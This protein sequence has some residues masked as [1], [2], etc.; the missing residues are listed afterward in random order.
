MNPP[1]SNAVQGGYLVAALFTGA[2]LGGLSLVFKEITE[3]LGCLLGGFC[4][5]MW[6][7]TVKSGGLVTESGAQTGFIIAFTVGFWCLSFSHYTRSYGLILCTSISGAT[8][9]T[10]GIDCYSR[11][12]LKEF[13]VYIW[14][15]SKRQAR[16]YGMYV[17]LLT[18]ASGLNN[19]LF[20]LN[21]N[22][23]PVSRNIRVELAITVIVTVFGVIAQMRL[24]KVIK[25]RRVKEEASRKEAEKKNEETDAEVGRQLE[26]KNLQE[27]AEWENMYGNGAANVP[28]MTE[29]AVAEDSRRGSDGFES[30]NQDIEKGNSFEMKDMP[31]PE[32]SADASDSGRNLDAVEEVE[33]EAFEEHQ[34]GHVIEPE[35]QPSQ[36]EIKDDAPQTARPVTM[37]PEPIVREDTGSEHGAVVGSEPGTPRSK[38]VSGMSLMKRL[39]RRSSN[40][41]NG[42]LSPRLNEK[43]ESEEALVVQDDATSSVLGVADDVPSICSSV[44]SEC[45]AAEDGKTPEECVKDNLPAKNILAEVTQAELNSQVPRVTQAQGQG[46]LASS[47]LPHT[48]NDENDHERRHSRND[49]QIHQD[50]EAEEPAHATVADIQEDSHL[51]KTEGFVLQVQPSTQQEGLS[52]QA[53]EDTPGEEYVKQADEGNQAP[54]AE[55]AEEEA[56]ENPPKPDTELVERDLDSVSQEKPLKRSVSARLDA[57]TVKEI[58]EQTSM[59]VNSF[60]TNEWA[61]HLADAEI[62][63]V[64]PIQLDNDVLE[65]FPADGEAAAP[66]DVEGL[67]QTPLNSLPPPIVNSPTQ[68]PASP[69]QIRQR[70]TASA[71]AAP[72][73]GVP[74]S[75]TRNNIYDMSGARSPPPMGR[76]MSSASL[77]PLQTR[78][79]TLSPIRSKSTPFLTIT[80]PDQEQKAFDSPRWSGPPPLLAVRENMVRNRM[81]SNSL[82][83]DP[84]ASRSQSR[85]SQAD[86]TLV[87]SSPMSIPE[88]RNEAVGKGAEDAD[89]VPLSKRRAML[90]RQHMRSPSTTS[91]L[92]IDPVRSSTL[93]PPDSGRSAAAMAAWRQSVRE[94][95]SQRDPLANPS[96]P[97][98]P[99]KSERPRAAWGSVQ[100]MRDTSV[101]HVEKSIAD[102]MQRGGM[103]D[104]HRQAMRRMQASANR[105]L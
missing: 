28:S 80:T 93:N 104:L 4:V 54:D 58:P 83:Y 17:Q 90:Q 19:N 16:T 5:A 66:V 48:G 26:E 88:E 11:A 40:G 10:L 77:L 12:G 56:E 100:Q 38:R 64:E 18:C 70:S 103:A 20:P 25:E 89:S 87:A 78:D 45:H 86:P 72:V 99:A 24:W 50:E 9:L 21:T 94:D 61:K 6:L 98:T 8:A 2:V 33:A 91:V 23:Y 53:K 82:R 79:E 34:D 74:R 101:A 30:S 43:S 41:V 65:S 105:K 32:H 47:L 7:L 68:P 52:D 14:G 3:G 60:R 51:K 81:S 42:P 63:E 1:V 44:V 59:V 96:S 29:T 69:E 97:A 13:W 75:K 35:H 37:W 76:N 95:L 57:S 15:K 46:Q 71:S 84:Y 36:D 85:L 31:A 39:S 67:L 102:R 55:Q 27:R 22:T 49:F 73:P 92:S 62:P